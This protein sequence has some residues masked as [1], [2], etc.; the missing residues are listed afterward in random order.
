MEETIQAVLGQARQNLANAHPSITP[1]EAY[2]LLGHVTGYSE[3]QLLARGDEILPAALAQSFRRL[4]RR[5]CHGEPA[6]YLLRRREFYGRDFFVDD[7]VLIPRPETEHLVEAVLGIDGL[8]P[9]PLLLD[10]GTGSGC[11]A[12]TLALEVPTARVLATDLSP[13]ALVVA[14]RN[15][16]IHQVE[17]RVSFLAADLWTPILPSTIDIVVSNPPYVAKADASSLPRDVRDFEPHLALFADEDGLAVYR[18]LF[19]DAAGLAQGARILVEIGLGQ[20]ESLRALAE[21]TGWQV[22]REIEDYG[23]IPRTVAFARPRRSPG[24]DD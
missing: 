19:E 4:I 12:V 16:R 17:D 14:R 9:N 11:L 10:L 5:R 1:R 24:K 7:R 23:G 18:R 8:P 2:L 20:L 22:I 15:A 6:A 3:A 13:A 21:A